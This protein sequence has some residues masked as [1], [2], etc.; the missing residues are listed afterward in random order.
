[1]IIDAG[2]FPSARPYFSHATTEKTKS[3]VLALTA[4]EIYDVNRIDLDKV[5]D[6][7]I[8]RGSEADDVIIV[9]HGTEVG[10]SFRLKRGSGRVTA[11]TDALNLLSSGRSAAS[12]AG[13]LNLSVSQTQSLQDRMR[14][15]QRLNMS[16]VEIRGCNI[17]QYQSTM[18][19]IR[20]FFGART[21]GAPSVRN[22]YASIRFATGASEA[23]FARI[24]RD[25]GQVFDVASGRVGYVI[26]MTAHSAYN[27]RS[28]YATSTAAIQEWQAAM[29]SF[30]DVQSGRFAIHGQ[31]V[32]ES[33]TFPSED[34]YTRNLAEFCGADSLGIA[35]ECVAPTAAPAAATP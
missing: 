33:L 18:S 7:I 34:A 20:R 27:I 30:R 16:R 23:N 10:M 28:A 32:S 35:N 15:V 25:N 26:R 12:I 9:C 17:G 11:Y 2:S 5:L 8:D 6:K 29:F 21:V 14:Q 3:S 24:E 31:F 4:N 22:S 19:A 13:Q 1:V